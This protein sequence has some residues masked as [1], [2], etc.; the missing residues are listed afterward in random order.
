MWKV[1][2]K[3]FKHLATFAKLFEVVEGFS[4]AEQCLLCGIEFQIGE[5]HVRESGIKLLDFKKGKRS[6][7]LNGFNL[8]C[9]SWLVKCI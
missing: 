7:T 5:A 1:D 8:I 4:N 9:Y 2:V 6:V 3:Q